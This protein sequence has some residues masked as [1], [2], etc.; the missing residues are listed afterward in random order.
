M[1]ISKDFRHLLGGNLLILPHDE[2]LPRRRALQPMFTK[3]R[4]SRYAGHMADAA[5]QVSATG[6]TTT[7]TSTCI[8]AD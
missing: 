7:S 6:G 4:V 8:A 3:Q 1:P 2:W 5:E